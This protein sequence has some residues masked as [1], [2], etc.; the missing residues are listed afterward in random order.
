MEEIEEYIEDKVI[1]IYGPR[2]FNKI[3]FIKE[4]YDFKRIMLKEF[5]GV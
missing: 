5:T 4:F 2:G 1:N 3:N